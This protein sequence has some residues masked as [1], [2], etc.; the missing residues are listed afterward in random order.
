MFKWQPSRT[1]LF[2]Q[3]GK[4]D[5]HLAWLEQ[6]PSYVL[7]SAAADGTNVQDLLASNLPLLILL[8]CTET[9]KYS[10]DACETLYAPLVEKSRSVSASVSIFG[11][12]IILRSSD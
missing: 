12:V 1:L 8:R 5:M 4:I 7:E 11:A 3:M 2:S 10:D 6:C 9:I